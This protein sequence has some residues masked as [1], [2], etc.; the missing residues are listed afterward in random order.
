[1]RR[2]G[3]VSFVVEV[4]RRRFPQNGA[5]TSD[6]DRKSGARIGPIG[7]GGL[8]VTP[9]IAREGAVIRR[10][11]RRRLPPSGSSASPALLNRHGRIIGAILVQAASFLVSSRPGRPTSRCK[12]PPATW[13]QP[14]RHNR[15]DKRKSR[16]PDGYC[17]VSSWKI[18]STLCFDKKPKND[19]PAAGGVARARE[20]SP[21]TGPRPRYR[22]TADR[23]PRTR[24]PRNPARALRNRPFRPTSPRQ[25]ASCAA[26]RS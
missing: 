13:S 25:A 14:L 11:K 18:Q 22:P 1:M 6:L 24:R 8:S 4:M 21:P 23:P 19:Q 5:T 12:S 3:S 7:A 9:L 15:T 17:K 20:A 10:S 2:R 26:A 16:D